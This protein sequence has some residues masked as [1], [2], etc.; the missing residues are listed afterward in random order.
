MGFSLVKNEAQFRSA[1][2]NVLNFKKHVYWNTVNLVV[3][4]S[5]S[6]FS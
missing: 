6:I 1:D 3:G 2:I 4:T 5:F